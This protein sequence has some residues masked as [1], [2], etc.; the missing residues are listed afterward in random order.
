LN[1]QQLL[2]LASHGAAARVKELRDE[3]ASIVKAFP[4]LRQARGRGRRPLSASKRLARRKATNGRRS[5]HQG[6]T[7]AQRKAAAA[8]MRAYWQKRKA[9][10]KK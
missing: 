4:G 1:R 2:R 3:I 10:R 7:A 9:G 5:R 8:R 6:W